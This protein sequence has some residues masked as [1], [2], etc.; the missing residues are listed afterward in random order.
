MEKPTKVI[1]KIDLDVEPDVEDILRPSELPVPSMPNGLANPQ[2]SDEKPVVTNDD[3]VD[4]YK[5]IFAYVEDDRKE[6]GDVFQTLFDMVI[7]DGDASH[8]TKEVMSQMLKLKADSTD[9]MTK[10]M[11]LLM[12]YILKDKDTFPRYMNSSVQQENNIIFKGSSK[13]AFL[14]KMEKAKTRKA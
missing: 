4:M 13:R 6:A 10:I 3:M 14:D 5:K 1:E 7:N 11:D 2:K 9:K 8:S 12:R